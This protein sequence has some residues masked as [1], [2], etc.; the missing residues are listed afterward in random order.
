MSKTVEDYKNSCKLLINE[1]VEKQGYEFS[2]WIGGVGTI[3][4]FIEQYYF[5][6]T[7]IAYDLS[8]NVSKGVIFEWQDHCIEYNESLPFD[9]YMKGKRLHYK[10]K[11]IKSEDTIINTTM[12][13]TVEYEYKTYLF[14][15]KTLTN[16]TVYR[17]FNKIECL[18]LNA[19]F[20]DEQINEIKILI[21]EYLQLR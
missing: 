14:K 13:V 12:V 20:T 3:A 5:D 16:S 7:D 21:N 9:K 10:S 11:V 6:T 18:T 17:T 19:K 4:C 2:G 1:F 15:V 8:N